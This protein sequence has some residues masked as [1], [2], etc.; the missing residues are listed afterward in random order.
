MYARWPEHLPADAEA[1]AVQLPGRET[2]LREQPIKDLA[3]IAD[4]V[5]RRIA[6]LRDRPFAFFGHSMGAL[7]AFEAARRLRD[8]GQAPAMLFA[9]GRQA[10]HLSQRRERLEGL[11]D[12]EFISAIA[13]LFGGVPAVLR[14]D[15][16]FRELYLPPLRADVA[17]VSQYRPSDGPALECPI[18]ALGG[19]SDGSAPRE[20]LHA[21]S[22]HTS[23]RFEVHLFPGDH[24]FVSTARAAVLSVVAAEVARIDDGAA[25]RRRV[26]DH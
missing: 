7:I 2:R 3:A 11:S 25:D 23:S 4:E 10:P 5:A 14:E 16:A 22:R 9:S 17:A 19:M 24:F 26:D 13:R 15:P 12:D 8:R 21:W 6:P 18:H 1:W 20:S